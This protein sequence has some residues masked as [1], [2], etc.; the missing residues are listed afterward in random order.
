MDLNKLTPKEY[1]AYVEKMTPPSPLGKNLVWAFCV[2]GGICA[3]V[4]GTASGVEH[5]QEIV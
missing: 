3:A 5:I 2:G 4:P 1:N